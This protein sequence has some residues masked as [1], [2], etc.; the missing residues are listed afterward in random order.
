MAS[1]CNYKL[2]FWDFDGV[3]K[4]S[5][6]VKTQAFIKIFE[7]F[8]EAHTSRV[9]D[10]HTNH[11]GMSRF[12][13]LP[14]YLQ[15]AGEQLSQARVNALCDQFSKLVVQGVIDSPWVPG[16]ERYLRSNFHQQIFILVSAT[17]Q[18]ELEEILYALDLKGCF[19]EIFGA[20]TPKKDAIRKT[21]ESTGLPCY[22]CLMIGDARADLDA[23][24]ANNVPFLLRRHENNLEVF[25]GYTGLSIMDFSTL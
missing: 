1:A 22:D 3:I 13:K 25:G 16:V 5:I 8:G 24:E 7:K 23:A 20:P 11:G 14:L 4:E 9:R 6:E 18:D 15:W 17:P 19:S 2:I 21:L 10:H 12:D